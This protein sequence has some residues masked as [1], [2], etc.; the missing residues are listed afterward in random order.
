MESYKSNKRN[1][2]KFFGLYTAFFIA[3]FA[4]SFMAFYRNGK[5]F[6]WYDGIIQHYPALV[7]LGDYVREVVK[8]FFSGTFELPMIDFNLAFGQN[9]LPILNP[10]DGVGDPLLLL[11]ALV[12]VKYSEILYNFLV[13]LRMYLAGIAFAMFCFYKKKTNV[14]TLLGALIYV[15]CG[16][17]LYAG[18]RHPSFLNPMIFLPIMLIGIDKIIKGDKPYLFILSV[19]VAAAN[20][21][22]FMYINTIFIFIYALT[23]YF[24][25]H[26]KSTI[27]EFLNI[28]SK[29][30]GS[31]ILGLIM[32][33]F[34]FLPSVLAFLTSARGGYKSDPGNLLLYDIGYYYKLLPRFVVT[35]ASWKYISLS[36]IAL[37]AIVVLIMRR[38]KGYRHLKWL[39]GICLIFYVSPLGGYITNGFSY[40]SG[41]WTYVFSFFISLAVVYALPS[42]QKLRKKELWACA[43]IVALYGLCIFEYFVKKNTGV[44][45]G[46]K[47]L[48]TGFIALCLIQETSLNLIL[49][50][51][52]L[53]NKNSYIKRIGAVVC[54]ALVSLNLIINANLFYSEN[55]YNYITEFYNYGEALSNYT[56]AEVAAALPLP[57]NEYYRVDSIEKKWQNASMIL[58]YPSATAY[59]SLINSNVALGLRELEDSQLSQLFNLYGLDNRTALDALASIKYIAIEDG[60]HEGYVPFGFAPSYKRNRNNKSYTIYENQYALPLGYTYSSYITWDEYEKMN[61]LEKQEAILQSVVLQEENDKYSRGNPTSTYKEIDYTIEDMDG[62]KWENGVLHVANNR[63]SITLSF[64]GLP[65]SE[66][67]IRIKNLDIDKSNQ[68]NFYVH[69]SSEKVTKTCRV[70]SSSYML[71]MGRKDY[72]VNIGYSEEGKKT[73]QI[74][75]TA[76]GKF[77]L[78]DI[79]VLCQPMDNYID[80]VTAL[81]EETLENIELSTNKVKGS[82]NLSSDK[83]LC[84]SLGF[85]DGWTAIVD[86][87]E[88]EILKANGMFMALP[89]TKGYHEIELRYCTPGIKAGII[90]SVLGIGYFVIMVLRNRYKG[91]KITQDLSV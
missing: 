21:F 6:M 38:R 46:Y 43:G 9:I 58:G 55:H 53:K 85:G 82:I 17:T 65:N 30:V 71:T 32:A 56:N 16:Y 22:Y 66:T 73:A 80:Q 36:I 20:S 63:G 52:G 35:W 78:D 31:Y 13:V 68:E 3:I 70:M 39:L 87:K 15:F 90:L 27:K 48:L 23:L 75:F 45:Y 42:I 34:I 74:T 60:A 37:F 29:G 59:F 79:K 11:S 5:S 54:C 25:E 18:V 57:D 14:G 89:L 2:L 28:F 7:Y 86:G 10:F 67:Y 33:G 91:V 47:M 77:I 44:V 84:L 12:P 62:V 81:G 19:F 40:V 49:E 88:V 69:V 72:L 83:I 1:F 8:N 4:L 51:I 64:D 41:R 61:A 24:H 76:K 26:R 50:K